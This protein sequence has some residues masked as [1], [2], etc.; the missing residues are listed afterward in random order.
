MSSLTVQNIQGSASSSNTINVASGHKIS[1]AA[2]SIIQPGMTLQ[3]KSFTTSGTATTT[4]NSFVDTG[5]FAAQFDN[6]LQAN[7][8]VFVLI[9]AN[10]G[11]P[12]HGNWARLNYLTIL[13][14]STD[15][16]AASDLGIGGD[17]PL[18]GSW[19]GTGYIQ[20]D[21]TQ[22]SGTLQFTP[23]SNNPTIKLA[24]RSHTS[25]VGLRVGGNYNY[26][27]AAYHTT[28]KM[29]IQEIAG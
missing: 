29:T 17:A 3:T 22:I 8:Q 23:S 18:G 13:D 2:G 5:L 19:A 14:G 21:T 24:Y 25:G 12:Y 1:G 20:Y 15:K 6:T 11:Q 28:T 10:I 27:N 7:S 26:G 9:H 4:S 16:G